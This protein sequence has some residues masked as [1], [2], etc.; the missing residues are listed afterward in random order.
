MTQ[1][2]PDNFE[3]HVVEHSRAGAPLL[4]QVGLQFGP[5]ATEHECRALLDSVQQMPMFSNST[6]AVR[7]RKRH[8]PDRAVPD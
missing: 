6:F 8:R 1:P 7:K 3:W 2:A 5:F 4:G